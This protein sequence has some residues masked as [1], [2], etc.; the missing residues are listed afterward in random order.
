VFFTAFRYGGDLRGRAG[1]QSGTTETKTKTK[2]DVKAAKNNP[3][4]GA[5][6]R[7][8]AAA[9][10]AHDDPEGTEVTRS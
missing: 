10:N 9:D 6:R 7:I 2:I 8:P 3:I 5:W 1:A 4:S